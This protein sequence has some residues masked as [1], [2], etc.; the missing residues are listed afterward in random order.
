MKFEKTVL[1]LFIIGLL[2]RFLN[3]EGSSFILVISLFTLSIC[4][5]PLGFIFLK[6]RK[7]KTN[8][9]P[10]SILTGFVF[11]IATAGVLFKLV[12]WPGAIFLLVVGLPASLLTL[13]I[14]RAK[15]NR[16]SENLKQYY[17]LLFKRSV[18]FTVMAFLLLLIPTSALIKIHFRKDP[19]MA[20][21]TI[22]RH[23]NPGNTKYRQQLRDYVHA[24]DSVW[25]INNRPD[26][27]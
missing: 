12:Y 13:I 5:F 19:E 24:K 3:W 26:R 17:S 15:Q 27:K 11:S 10:S 22:L 4:Y 23:E 9:I 8:N 21:L 2:F 18:I 1:V 16:S 14:T 7:T 25:A 6:D 20:R